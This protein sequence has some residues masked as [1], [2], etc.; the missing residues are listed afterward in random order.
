[1][2][3]FVL[4][5]RAKAER[6][7]DHLR[8]ATHIKNSVVKSGLTVPS[9]IKDTLDERF[10]DATNTAVADHVKDKKNT[11]RYEMIIRWSP[12]IW[13]W[14]GIEYQRLGF[15]APYGMIDATKRAVELV[16]LMNDVARPQ[17]V[18]KSNGV[19]LIAVYRANSFQDWSHETLHK[20]DNQRQFIKQTM[21]EI[22]ASKIKKGSVRVG[23]GGFVVDADKAKM[24]KKTR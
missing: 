24:L 14:R 10:K 4:N 15:K 19:E 13:A 7:Q 18:A 8:N 2:S 11:E 5:L 22:E 23:T 1:M 12:L 9:S 3:K 16:T 17:G 6:I 21:D 20:V